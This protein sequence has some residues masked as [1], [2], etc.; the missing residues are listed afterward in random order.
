MISRINE[1]LKRSFNYKKLEGFA[2]FNEIGQV[3]KSARSFLLSIFHFL[4]KR[5]ILWVTSSSSEAENIFD[6]SNLFLGLKDD[7]LIYFPEPDENAVFESERINALNRIAN[8]LNEKFTIVSS[9]RALL[10]KTAVF[11]DV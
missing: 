1:F 9:I 11:D 10:N 5:N 2:E 4:S 8:S 6:D 7:K 3:P